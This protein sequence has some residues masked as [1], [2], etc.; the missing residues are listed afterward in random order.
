MSCS[1]FPY[2][3][4]LSVRLRAEVAEFFEP[5][6]EA[7]VT[8][9]KAQIDSSG[10]VVKVSVSFLP[11]IFQLEINWFLSVCVASGRFC[12]E[13]LVIQPA[14][15]ASCALGYYGQQTRQ[16]NVSASIIETE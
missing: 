5:S 4:Y 3:T 2:I 8:S 1:F 7:A 11:S 13:S 14:S 10:G 9:I 12:S 6:I 15:R 16:S